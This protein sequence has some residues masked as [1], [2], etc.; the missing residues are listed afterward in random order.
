[1]A[2][3]KWRKNTSFPD[4]ILRYFCYYMGK[5]TDLHK[6]SSV[7]V[8]E[9]I[10]PAKEQPGALFTKRRANLTEILTWPYGWS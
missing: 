3:S 4:Y 1:M 8:S 7:Q 2:R 6:D 9:L 10:R 5:C